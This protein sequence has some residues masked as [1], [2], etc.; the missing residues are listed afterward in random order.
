MYKLTVT[1]HNGYEHGSIDA[2]SLEELLWKMGSKYPHPKFLFS[3]P[4]PNFFVLTSGAVQYDLT[5][6]IT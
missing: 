1:D 2:E 5:L 6:E 3:S 4:A